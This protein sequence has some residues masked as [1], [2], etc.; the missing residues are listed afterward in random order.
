MTSSKWTENIEALFARIKLK[1]RQAFSEFY[2]QTS[3]RLY[4][5]ILKIIVDEG[6]A[7]DLLQECYQKIWV[8]A[9]Q[10]QASKGSSWSWVCQLTR[11]HT[12]DSYRKLKRAP[13]HDEFDEMKQEPL[14]VDGTAHLW[15]EYLSLGNCL[16]A[17]RQEQQ[18]VIL[19]AYVYGWSHSE[20][21]AKF[22][23]PLGTIKSWIRRGL[24]ELRECLEA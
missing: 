17:I 12:I 10:H 7:Q 9:S 16:S 14:S 21:V 6:T 19:S 18:S 15:P 8:S 2:D 1:D 11:N 23:L 13:G 4:G 24:Q 5:L 3:S 22:N 20:L